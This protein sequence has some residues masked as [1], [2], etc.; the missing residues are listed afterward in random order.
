M[1]YWVPASRTQALLITKTF[2]HTAQPKGALCCANAQRLK[3]F[4]RL[5]GLPLFIQIAFHGKHG[6]DGR[7]HWP[8]KLGALSLSLGLNVGSDPL[9]ECEALHEWHL[10][11]PRSQH[12]HKELSNEVL[13][14]VW[15]SITSASQSRFQGPKRLT[16]A[17]H[18]CHSCREALDESMPLQL[19][20]G[21]SQGHNHLT[22]SPQD[23]HI[24]SKQSLSR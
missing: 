1:E 18:I 9:R 2:S 23:S 7:P 17:T 14:Q 10:H 13:G 16:R 12:L 21:F 11:H 4:G 20:V 3:S 22:G 15:L 8:L 6:A 24:H 5:E 19:R